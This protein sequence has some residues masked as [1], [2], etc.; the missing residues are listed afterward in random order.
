MI[1]LIV[2][3]LNILALATVCTLDK[4]PGRTTFILLNV[5]SIIANAFCL[6]K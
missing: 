1:S 5:A 6:L 2:I 4:G 3:I